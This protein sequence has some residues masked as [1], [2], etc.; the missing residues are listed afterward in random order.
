V[1]K[2]LE[3]E[4]K[5][6]K[7]ELNTLIGMYSKWADMFDNVLY[8]NRENEGKMI[9]DQVRLTRNG[10]V[11]GK[12]ALRIQGQKLLFDRI[13]EEAAITQHYKTEFDQLSDQASHCLGQIIRDELEGKAENLLQLL[14]N[15]DLSDT[16][17]AQIKRSKRQ[18]FM[19]FTDLM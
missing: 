5:E 8:T 16:F 17:S 1:I 10:V 11:L 18:T 14:S 7:P 15:A 12:E 6:E 9:C 2:V 3:T 4:K 19:Q 13:S